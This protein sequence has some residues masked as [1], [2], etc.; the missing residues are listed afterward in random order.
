MAWSTLRN[1]IGPTAYKSMSSANTRGTT[2]YCSITAT[3][4]T[5]T[6]DSHSMDNG[7]PCGMP[8]RFWNARPR[9]PR[10][11]R[12][13][14]TT[15]WTASQQRGVSGYHAIVPGLPA[16]L[17]WICHRCDPAGQSGCGM[18]CNLM[19]T[20]RV[21]VNVPASG[22]RTAI[23]GSWTMTSWPTTAS[24]RVCLHPP[25]AD[26]AERHLRDILRLVAASHLRP[27]RTRFFIL[28]D[29]RDGPLPQSPPAQT[30]T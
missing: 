25:P 6:M 3:Q 21:V 2:P 12:I 9:L 24:L 13:Q 27:V 20:P 11:A 26:G 5:S 22:A 7:H 17:Y 18:R 19:V 30:E 15:S 10:F 1:A 8:V 29:P 16:R 4:M 14:S 28:S 23:S